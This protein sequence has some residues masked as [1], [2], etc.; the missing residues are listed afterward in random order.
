ML[1]LKKL[2]DLFCFIYVFSIIWYIWRAAISSYAWVWRYLFRCTYSFELEHLDS[3]CGT[4][5]S[6]GNMVLYQNGIV[7]AQL[8][9]TGYFPVATSYTTNYVGK[10][11][12]VSDPTMD[13]YIDE[14]RHWYSHGAF[15]YFF[16]FF[17]FYFKCYFISP[18]IA[19]TTDRSIYFLLF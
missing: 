5:D 12:W 14:F 6:S 4:V 8:L 7:W 3:R 1:F 15:F 17:Y 9:N 18:R 2:C 13:G 19:E 16:I 10:S 11:N